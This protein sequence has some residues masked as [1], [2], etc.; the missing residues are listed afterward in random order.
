MMIMAVQVN[1][2]WSINMTKI[3]DSGPV[4]H[5]ENLHRELGAVAALLTADGS[6]SIP[7]LAKIMNVSQ[8]Y[9]Y[10]QIKRGYLPDARVLQIKNLISRAG[11]DLD[12]LPADKKVDFGALRPEQ[13]IRCKYE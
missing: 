6:S 10:A 2:K 8:Q 7:K 4:K 5:A 11:I 1:K 12:S 9:L 13:L 3:T